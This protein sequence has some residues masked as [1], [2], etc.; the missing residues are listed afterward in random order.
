MWSI[1][2]RRFFCGGLPLALRCR[3]PPRLLLAAAGML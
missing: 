3:V 1:R 2:P